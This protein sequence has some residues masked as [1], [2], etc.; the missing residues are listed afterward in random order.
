[1]T[2][3]KIVIVGA[4]AA[5]VFTAWRVKEMFGDQ[6]DVTLLEASDR[7]GGNTSS[8]QVTYGGTNYNIDA[9]AQFFYTNPQPSYV[10]LLEQLGLFDPGQNLII[11]RPTGVILWDAAANQRRFWVPSNPADFITRYTADDWGRLIEFGL[12]FAYCH[13][14]DT[15]T[16]PDWTLSVDDWLAGLTLVD[17]TFRDAVVKPFL[18]QFT[19]IA[20]P[21]IG[22]ASALYSITYLA[23][24]PVFVTYQSLIGL[25]GI[26]QRVL[27]AAGVTAQ[28]NTP[29][30][31]VARHGQHVVVDTPNGKL[32][33]DDVVLAC[34]PGTSADL[35][36]AGATSSHALIALLRSLPY[37]PLQISMQKDGAC[38]MP[39][40]QSFWEPVSSVVNSSAVSFN[41]WFGPLRPPYSGN[42]LIPVFKSWGAPDVGPCSYQFFEHQHDVLLPTT[43]FLAARDQLPPWQGRDGVWFAGGW[44]NW[45]D[46]QE[47]AL[48][49]ATSIAEQLPG[50]VKANTG[51]ARMIAA[52]ATDK[53]RNVRRWLEQVSRYAPDATT[54]DQLAGALDE[55]EQHG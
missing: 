36:A 51:R 16:S 41:A 47:A 44:T 18:Y 28:L 40:D 1:M 5:G 6:Y 14:L 21:Q 53:K 20:L 26:L 54:R 12:F 22:G 33:A 52:T 29:V 23:R 50:L 7:V 8:L 3:R 46:S 37:A 24:N 17:P 55:V 42:Q 27:T 34:D 25:D 43:G 30:T 48:E 2:P 4:G 9:G 10:A 15:A 45:F 49:S 32:H 35:L 31:S 39:G 13:F 38:F 11:E 19:S